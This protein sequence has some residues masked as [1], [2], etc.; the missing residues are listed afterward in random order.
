MVNGNHL[1]TCHGL[2]SLLHSPSSESHGS[3]HLHSGF[4][5]SFRL[6][7]NFLGHLLRA[8]PCSLRSSYRPVSFL[9]SKRA[10]PVGSYG[11]NGSWLFDIGSVHLHSCGCGA[12]QENNTCKYS[13]RILV[14]FCL[15]FPVTGFHVLVSCFSFS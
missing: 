2:P 10:V 7:R 9:G 5:D 8:L 1:V 3:P 6:L 14:Q 12:H 13:I 11:E 15:V 4:P